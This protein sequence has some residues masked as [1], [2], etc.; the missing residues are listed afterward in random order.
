[1]FERWFIGIEL[2]VDN[3]LRDDSSQLSARFASACPLLSMPQSSS[4]AFNTQRVFV[5][6]LT[7]AN[8]LLI[9]LRYGIGD[10]VME[11]PVLDGL[12]RLLPRALIKAVGSRPAIEL[13]QDDP[14]V[15]EVSAVQDFGVRHWGDPGDGEIREC[16][17][18]WLRRQKYD[19][20]LDVSHAAMAVRNV[21]WE[22]ETAILDA[23]GEAHDLALKEGL[24]GAAAIKRAVRA[25]WGLNVPEDLTPRIHFGKGDLRFA[26]EYLRGLRIQGAE[27]IG[28]SPIASSP[29]KRWPPE[30]FA[31]VADRMIRGTGCRLLLFCGPQQNMANRMLNHMHH[32]GAVTVV[33]PIHLR[34][35][36]VLLARCMLFVGND[37][38]LMHMAAALGVPTVGIFGPTCPAIY[39]PHG[40][41]TRGVASRIPCQYRITEAFGPPECISQSRCLKGLGTCIDQVQAADVLAATGEVS[42]ANPLAIDL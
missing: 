9:C 22:E 32:P 15:D 27:L 4:S 25:G 20:V 14:R 11:T 17:R 13:L 28:F 2:V 33:G 12:R 38:G 19:L 8:H 35:V 21:I 34:R 42:G 29:L 3:S 16:I 37:T 23:S 6:D 36:A 1:V 31:A 24:C 10:L 30:R 18:S 26:E 41:H 7:S 39:L 40:F 5:V